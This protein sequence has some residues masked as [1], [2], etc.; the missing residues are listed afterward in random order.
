MWNAKII[1][2]NC[3][4]STKTNAEFLFHYNEK[5]K[6]SASTLVHIVFQHMLKNEDQIKR[7]KK[8]ANNT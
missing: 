4:K 8:K 6:V 5:R 7:Y 1:L 2:G 3:S